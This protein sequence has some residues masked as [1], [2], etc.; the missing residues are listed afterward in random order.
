M[1]PPATGAVSLLTLGLCDGASW[2]LRADVISGGTSVSEQGK[3]SRS[4]PG[5]MLAAGITLADPLAPLTNPDAVLRFQLPRPPTP[6]PRLLPRPACSHTPLVS[7]HLRVL[8]SASS[9]ASVQRAG[10]WPA[11]LT[12]LSGP[13]WPQKR[14][15]CSKAN[16]IINGVT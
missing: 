3:R 10:F 6:A 8:P 13:P 7:R 4:H 11:W 15:H 5:Q 2:S 14:E 9:P 12:A 1:P 16:T